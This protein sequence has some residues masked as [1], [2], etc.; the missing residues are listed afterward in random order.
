MNPQ[1]KQKAI[2]LKGKNI[3]KLRQECYERADGCCEKCG[4]AA[5]WDGGIMFMGHMHHIKH[6]SLG[7]SDTIK[8]VQWLCNECHIGNNGE[9]GT[10]WSLKNE[11][12]NN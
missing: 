3:R 7:G 9:H 10:R 8:N 2:R 1:P 4:S 6:R 11:H 5:P 12:E